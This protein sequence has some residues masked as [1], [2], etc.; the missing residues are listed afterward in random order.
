MNQYYSMKKDFDAEINTFWNPALLCLIPDPA[1]L[2]TLETCGYSKMFSRLWEIFEWLQVSNVVLEVV[3]AQAMF[4]LSVTAFFYSKY[5]AEPDSGP[6]SISEIVL[7]VKKPIVTKCS[8]LDIDRASRNLWFE[9]ITFKKPPDGRYYTFR[10]RC[11]TR[12]TSKSTKLI[13]TYK[14]TIIV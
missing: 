3:S 14:I 1:L 11:G 9:E 13:L 10:K 8:I 7:F 4:P 2:H 5:E 6:L 12:E